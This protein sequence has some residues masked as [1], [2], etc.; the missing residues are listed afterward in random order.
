MWIWVWYLRGQWYIMKKK[1][2]IKLGSLVRI[3]PESR[4][5]GSSVDNPI[6]TVGTVFSFI[7]LGDVRVRWSPTSTNSY[8]FSDLEDV[9]PKLWD[10][11]RGSGVL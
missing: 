2:E 11:L 7:A 6:N 4:Y 10:L 9:T 5:Y 8:Y 1:R 3:R